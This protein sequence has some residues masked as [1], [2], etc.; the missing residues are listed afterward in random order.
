MAA[1]KGRKS[2]G[3]HSVRAAGSTV[4]APSSRTSQR[5][6]PK[7]QL[8]GAALYT[9]NSSVL[10]NRWRPET[11]RP[12][13]LI[14]VGMH[15]SGTSAL[16]YCLTRLGA[17]LPLNIVG[18]GDAN[19]RG[20]WE[21]AKI[22]E[23]NDRYLAALGSG[24]DDWRQL[25]LD[26]VSPA[27]KASFAREIKAT[28][29]A[30]YPGQNLLMLKDPRISRM[31]PFYD[32]TLR[33]AGY[34]PR[35]ILCMRNPNEVAASLAARDG[36]GQPHAALLWLRHMLDAEAATRSLPRSIHGFD[37]LLGDWRHSLDVIGSDLQLEW[38]KSIDEAAD[39]VDAFLDR[40]LRHHWKK[41]E[42]ISGPHASWLRRA[43]AGLKTAD[44]RSGVTALNAVR[45][46]FG[47]Y[48]AAVGD[49]VLPEIYARQRRVAEEIAL[50]RENAEGLAVRLR[51]EV[52]RAEQ[53]EIVL[54]QVTAELV[55]LRDR[56]ESKMPGDAALDAA[57]AELAERY[58]RLEGDC[59][60]LAGRHLRLEQDHAELAERYGR[61]EGDCVGLAGRHLR[62]EQDH[63]SD[64]SACNERIALLEGQLRNAI[65]QQTKASDEYLRRLSAMSIRATDQV[66]AA[67][68]AAERNMTEHLALSEKQTA[69]R[70]S[71]TD[72][73]IVAE[74]EAARLAVIVEHQHRDGVELEA[75]QQEFE[76]LIRS[77][78]EGEQS[79][80]TAVAD[81]TA[82]RDAAY[83][84]LREARAEKEGLIQQM[85]AILID[86]PAQRG[87]NLTESD[88]AKLH[89]EIEAL[90]RSTSWKVTAPLRGVG[91]ILGRGQK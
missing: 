79:L 58:G 83:D 2:S 8:K 37:S 21:P 61:L 15:R 32:A 88:M 23:L 40:G 57:H 65:E 64:V 70:V 17:G 4:K 20:H 50:H 28:V 63:V 80:K 62:L 25:D 74:R 91:R 52:E 85:G 81:R 14:V 67:L 42:T 89:E 41:E 72:R 77:Y 19:E 48:A 33:E 7:A 12:V 84:R 27:L 75:V 71:L 55:D 5:P 54:K 29:K 78:K 30:E 18:A 13:V 76:Q 59:V 68:R 39:E 24:W 3:R 43:W 6:R 53:A 16:G 69:E 35:Y 44:T 60:G 45:E 1:K 9:P 34:D 11:S 38:P 73:L 31:I 87:A 36:I 86:G 22:I 66:S 47:D 56:L 46:E 82:E 49:Q 90:R 51:A 26:S 10:E